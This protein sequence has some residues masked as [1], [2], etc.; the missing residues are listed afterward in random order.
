MRLVRIDSVWQIMAFL[1][2]LFGTTQP[3]ERKGPPPTDKAKAPV[4]R[5]NSTSKPSDKARP[6]NPVPT[7]FE[8]KNRQLAMTWD[9]FALEG[10]VRFLLRRRVITRCA[11]RTL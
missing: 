3:A 7:E 6:K 10:K 9:Q 11:R 5:R 2:K 8:F 4:E 1:Q